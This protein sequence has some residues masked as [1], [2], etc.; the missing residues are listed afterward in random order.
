MLSIPP[1][2]RS[3]EPVDF[4]NRNHRALFFDL[5]LANQHH[6]LNDYDNDIVL[7][8]NGFERRQEIG[9][10][11]AFI[12]MV[13]GLEVG[14]FWIEIDRY[15][16][17]RVRGALFSEYRNA[18]NGLFF[19][20]M[21]VMVGFEVLGLRKLDSELGLYPKQDRE[22]AAAERILKRIGFKKRAILPEAMMIGGKPR[23][24]ILLDFLKRDYDGKQ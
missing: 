3:I 12:A 5:A 7:I 20:K 17:G 15:G 22:S 4:S 8:I 6:L 14:C 21:M 1:V 2:V 16:V 19:L 11:S 13:D 9:E 10:L 23:D 24:T 18:W